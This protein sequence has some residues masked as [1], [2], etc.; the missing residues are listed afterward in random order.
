M[1]LAQGGIDVRD[2]FQNTITDDGS[3]RTVRK[4]QVRGAAANGFFITFAFD[5]PVDLVQV[6]ID[7]GFQLRP[8]R[9][10]G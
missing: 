10:T 7:P 9:D 4:R 5:R 3:K 8:E 6:Q 1:D 2:M